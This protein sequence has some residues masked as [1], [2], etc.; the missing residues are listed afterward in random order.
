[1]VPRD[2]LAAATQR[3][4]EAGNPVVVGLLQR[5]AVDAGILV[6]ALADLFEQPVYLPVAAGTSGVRSADPELIGREVGAVLGLDLG[7]SLWRGFVAS[8]ETEH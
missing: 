2:V 3:V 8:G 7:Q 1:M 4:F 6:D 5:A